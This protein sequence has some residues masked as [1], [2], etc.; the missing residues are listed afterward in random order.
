MTTLTRLQTHHLAGMTRA[1]LEARIVNLEATL[2]GRGAD[3]ERVTGERDAA[4]LEITNYM[5]HVGLNEKL[6]EALEEWYL[7]CVGR[8]KGSLAFKLFYAYKAVRDGVG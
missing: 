3:L 7:F 2:E 6:R 8:S 1:E 4:R 5:Q